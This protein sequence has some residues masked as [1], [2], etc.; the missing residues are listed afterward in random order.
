M[1]IPYYIYEI[2]IKPS[3]ILTMEEARSA[4]GNPNLKYLKFRGQH[5]NGFLSNVDDYKGSGSCLKEIRKYLQRRD[6]IRYTEK[7]VFDRKIFRTC[8]FGNLNAFSI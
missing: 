2:T 8:C 4:V 5:K 1:K 7:E 6:N 3:I